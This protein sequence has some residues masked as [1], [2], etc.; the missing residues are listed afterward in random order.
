MRITP[1][2]SLLAA[3]ALVTV[4][5]PSLAQPQAVAPPA[6][7]QSAD[8]RL[9]ALYE[10][11]AN[12]DQQEGGYFLDSKGENQSA[13]YLPKVDPATQLARAKFEQQMLDQLNAIPAANLSPD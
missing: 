12:W 7:T 1:F 10:A 11:Y 3:A 4:A 2:A 8:A 13:A 5:S 9:K 6:P